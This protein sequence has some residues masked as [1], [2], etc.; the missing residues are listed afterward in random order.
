MESWP[1]RFLQASPM[2][3]LPF[4]VKVKEIR[5]KGCLDKARYPSCVYSKK[6]TPV[7]FQTNQVD[8]YSTEKQ[9][10]HTYPPY[11]VRLREEPIY[12]VNKIK[13][14]IGTA[15]EQKRKVCKCLYKPRAQKSTLIASQSRHHALEKTEQKIL[16]TPGPGTGK[17]NKRVW[18]KDINLPSKQL[19]PFPCQKNILVNTRKRVWWQSSCKSSQ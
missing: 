15:I 10:K 4:N 1:N 14:S 2:S 13:G 19:F 3:V 9:K 11:Y 12:P 16:H 6:Q 18:R 17:N 8:W 5:I 7:S